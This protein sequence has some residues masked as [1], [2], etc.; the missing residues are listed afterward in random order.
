MVHSRSELAKIGEAN[1]EF[2]QR[3]KFFRLVS[4]RRYAYLVD[5]VPKAIALMRVI[6][7]RVGRSLS[8]SGAD[9]NQ[10]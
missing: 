1:A 9:E 10:S 6:V 3:R 5:C 4:A 8:S 2:Q 7:A